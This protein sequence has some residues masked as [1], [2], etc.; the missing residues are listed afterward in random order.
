MWCNEYGNMIYTH[1]KLI[2]CSNAISSCTN[3]RATCNNMYE[4]SV[5][6]L[7]RLCKSC[8]VVV[9]QR[10]A[11]FECSM[12]VRQQRCGNQSATVEQPQE[13][14]AQRPYAK[15]C[16]PYTFLAPFCCMMFRAYLAYKS[17]HHT[18]VSELCFHHI[19]IMYA[20]CLLLLLL[21]LL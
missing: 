16:K 14:S 7:I 4:V 21:L 8:W 18:T 10:I 9:V 20:C 5:T 6:V 13:T 3:I 11:V 17:T 19:I 15:P 12:S 1:C 2:S